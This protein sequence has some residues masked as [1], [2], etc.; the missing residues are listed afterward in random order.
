MAQIIYVEDDDLMGSVVRDILA[1]AGHIVRVIAHGT[2]GFET[3]A[4][5]EPDVVIL[6]LMLP[7]MSGIEI[8]HALRTASTTCLT[9]ILVL[10]ASRGKDVPDAVM[11]AGANDFMTKPFTADALVERVARVI[12]QNQLNLGPTAAAKA[13]SLPG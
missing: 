1:T 12:R 3:I 2:L 7:G 9:P 11:S 4:F 5:K 13:A 10:T 6:D 8:I